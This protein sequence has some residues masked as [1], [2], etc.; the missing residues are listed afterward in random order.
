MAKRIIHNHPTTGKMCVY[1][2]APSFIAMLQAENPDWSEED[3][4]R[5]CANKDI[6]TGV[7]YEIIE[8]SDLETAFGTEDGAVDRT[9]RDAW[10]FDDTDAP[11]TVADLSDDELA[12]YGM[13]EQMT[14]ST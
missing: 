14:W 10:E 9:F 3:C 6:P 11:E 2:P 13:T 1:T 8:D 7:A 12:K 5:H 4:L